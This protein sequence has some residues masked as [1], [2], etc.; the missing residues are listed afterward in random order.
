MARI[1]QAGVVTVMRRT[2]MVALAMLVSVSAAA[3]TQDDLFN[4]EVL[5]RVELW[6]NAADWSKLKGAFQ[7]NTD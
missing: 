6:M 1:T 7:E 3:Q 5:Q 4:P 2:C